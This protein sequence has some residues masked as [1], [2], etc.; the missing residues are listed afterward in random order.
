M[1][2]NRIP[3]FDLSFAREPTNISIETRTV[4]KSQPR[5]QDILRG[6]CVP[7]LLPNIE[8]AVFM[9]KSWL[10]FLEI[11]QRPKTLDARFASWWR[12]RWNQNGR[13]HVKHFLPTAIE[14]KCA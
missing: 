4:F 1:A 6:S 14:R 5:L 11:I 13:S 12:E 9:S 10:I 7:F 3:W 8:H 2:H